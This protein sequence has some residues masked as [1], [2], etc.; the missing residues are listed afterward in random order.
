MP[1]SHDEVVHC[2]K[3]IINKLNGNDANK[4]AQARVLYLYMMLHPGKKLNFMG[5]ELAMIREW[6]EK[7]EL[8]W[9]LLNNPLHNTF[10]KYILQL[11]KIYM[12]EGAIWELDH[13]YDG[14]KWIDCNSD[15]NCVFAFTRTGKQKRMLVVLNFSDKEV[16]INPN[17]DSKCKMILNTDWEMFGGNTP[18]SY[19]E[20]IERKVPSFTGH[21]YSY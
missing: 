15:N 2:K 20:Q 13:T 21:L 14:F 10:N 12:K 19:Q 3:T 16:T 17:L 8:D 7:R 9:D 6:N 1:F 18:A 4:F 11:N 5:N